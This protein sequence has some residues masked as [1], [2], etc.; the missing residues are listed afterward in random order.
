MV[1]GCTTAV[2]LCS[3]CAARGD[4]DA[5]VVS[6]VQGPFYL[7]CDPSAHSA[8]PSPPPGQNL[9]RETGARGRTVPGIDLRLA[10]TLMNLLFVV[11]IGVVLLLPETKGQPLPE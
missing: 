4:R 9:D 10:I 7:T 2:A 11:G 5:A 8:W 1:I 3:E 6:P